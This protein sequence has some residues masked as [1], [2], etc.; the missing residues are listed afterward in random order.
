M[1]EAAFIKQNSA[2][3]KSFENQDF[4]DPDLLADRFIQLTD[5][6]S[7]ARTFYPDSDNTLYLNALAARVHQAIYKNNRTRRNRFGQFW[8]YELPFLFWQHQKQL[9][10]AFIIFTA[11]AAIGV[12]S[13]AF[14]DTFVR[15]ILGDGYVNQTIANI[16]KGDPMAIY[17]QD[18]QTEMFLFIT[19]NN[20]KVAFFAF[21][22][23]IFFSVGT[24]W[25]LLSN[26]IMLGAFQYFF[27]KQ[28][29]LLPSVLTVWIHGTLEISAIVIAGCAGFVLGNSILFPK[30]YSRL[31]SFKRAS[32]QGLKI[33]V[34]L[35]PIFI[36]AGFL[37]SFVTRHTEM[38][39]A[40]SCFIILA[41]L[42]FILLYFIYYPQALHAKNTHAQLS[43]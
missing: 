30:T 32:R 12:L 33:T 15:L 16:K 41:S 42:F 24:F 31:D 39:L 8:R 29:L 19:L 1:R 5:D 34:G 28:G 25:I 40:L 27:Y 26:G 10:F 20:I 23:G 11:G 37:E 22:Y 18:G 38:P 6:L 17:K 43:S 2:K 21:V 7:F 36:T 4:L 13:A 35:V 9:I 14:D 3:W